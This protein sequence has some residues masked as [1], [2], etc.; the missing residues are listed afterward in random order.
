MDE[1]IVEISKKLFELSSKIKLLEAISWPQSA[2]REFIEGWH[3]GRVVFPQISYRQYDY[4]DLIA[5]LNKI[6][7]RLSEVSPEQALLRRT[8]LSC[9]QS[10]LL[11]EAIG[12]PSFGELS[13][14]IFGRPGDRMPGTHLTSVEAAEHFVN[15]A[16]TFTELA[17]DAVYDVCFSSEVLRDHLDEQVRALFGEEG[18]RVEV[19]PGLVSKATAGGK[20]VRLRK[21]TCFTEY[22]L[23]Q[24][25]MHEV[26][27]H[28]LTSINGYAQTRFKSLA[29]GVPRTT[30]TQ[31]GL[32]TFSELITGVIDL[33][34]LK[35]I[36]LRVLA[37][38]RALDGADFVEVFKYFMEQGQSEEESFRSTVRVFRG[39]FPDQAIIFTKDS[40]YLDGLIKVHTFFRWAMRGHHIDLLEALFCGRVALEDIAIVAHLIEQKQI[41]KPKFLPP[42]F[43]KIHRLGG[44][45][46][47]SLLANEINLREVENY[48]TKH[49]VLQ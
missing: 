8:A 40:I 47:F 15:I 14:Q 7:T 37:I 24:L 23:D 34:R 43:K 3:R 42:W 5:E 31:E 25:L 30:K 39:G 33:A 17:S 6:I 29:I 1:Q 20:R 45:L 44:I 49:V 41:A 16:N 46:A 48:F 36:A 9:L 19:V 32:A 13:L 4:Q 26:F 28:S 18:P 2:E 22:D 21:G 35:R 12:T 27:I 10:A 38:D 11:V